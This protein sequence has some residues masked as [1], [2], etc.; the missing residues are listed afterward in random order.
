[1]NQDVQAL[2]DEELVIEDDEAEGQGKHVVASAD[3][4][5]LADASLLNIGR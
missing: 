3:F 4:E 1:M 2:P 5:K